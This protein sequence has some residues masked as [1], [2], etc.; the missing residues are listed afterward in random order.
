MW[1]I[2]LFKTSEAYFVNVN[3][4][5]VI[6]QWIILIGIFYWLNPNTGDDYICSL[7]SA[8]NLIFLSFFD[9]SF[10]KY[11]LLRASVDLTLN[12]VRFYENIIFFFCKNWTLGP[13]PFKK[14]CLQVHI[15]LMR[16][17][18]HMSVIISS[19]SWHW[20]SI[21]YTPKC[22]FRSQNYRWQST[23]AMVTHSWQLLILKLSSGN[24]RKLT[25]KH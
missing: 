4:F 23:Y 18:K 10:C 22:S 7:F 16:H 15:T 5:L 21:T 1:W 11:M 8:Q 13:N 25:A 9:D 6:K 14:W 17:K 20:W 19:I 2:F 12:S 24:L 3:I